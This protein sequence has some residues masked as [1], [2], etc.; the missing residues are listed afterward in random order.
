MSGSFA[1]YVP[2]DS[3]FTL[4]MQSCAERRE[5]TCKRGVQVH[6]VLFR[7]TNTESAGLM[8]STWTR[9]FD[10]YTSI[11]GVCWSWSYTR[12]Y[13]GLGLAVSL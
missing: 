4:R 2:T 9:K 11:Y 13:N 1:R 8:N 3:V 6:S 7:E 12:K 10:G 5:K